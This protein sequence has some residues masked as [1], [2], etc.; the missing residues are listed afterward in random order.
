MIELTNANTQSKRHNICRHFSC[1]SVYAIL[2]S[3]EKA[4]ESERERESERELEQ[5]M[6]AHI[7]V[8]YNP[9]IF[10]YA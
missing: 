10:L 7:R 4:T 3:K 9:E 8:I 1:G 5:L 6:N 2:S